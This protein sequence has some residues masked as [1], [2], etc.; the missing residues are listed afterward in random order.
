MI[1]NQLTIAEVA[2]KTG[3][4]TK[5]VYRIIINEKGIRENTANYFRSSIES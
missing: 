1:D 3:V 2:K 4:L 5:R